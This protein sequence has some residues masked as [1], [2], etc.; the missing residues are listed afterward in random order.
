[1]KA[2][3]IESIC[4]LSPLQQGLIFHCLYSPESGVYLSQFN[5]A[6]PKLNI[7][8][9]K[10]SWQLMMERHSIFRTA[11]FWKEL[12]KPLQVVERRTAL[13]L[14]EK[15]WRHLS[16][17]EQQSQLE[18]LLEED[19]ARGF[20]LDHAPL[21]RLT[22]NRTGESSYQFIWTHHHLLLDGWSIAV[23]L[24][25]VFAHYEATLSGERLR[26]PPVRPFSDFIAWLSQRDEAGAER[27]WR[28]Y[29]SGF[30]AAT[31]L[32][33]SFDKH[34]GATGYGDAESR[35][36]IEQTEAVRT[37]ARRSRVTLNT[38]VGGAWAV[39]LARSAGV[40]EVVYGSVVSGRPAELE[41]VEGMV[42]L[43]INTLPVRVRVRGEQ[44]IGEWLQGLQREAAEVRQYEL[45]SLA[46]LQR[47]SEMPAATPLFQTIYGFENYPVDESLQQQNRGPEVSMARNPEQ[48]NYPLALIAMP[49]RQMHLQISYD[50]ALF[51]R[52]TVER[53]LGRLQRVLV[54][55]AEN[56][57]LPVSRLELL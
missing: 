44:P 34:E 7:E 20:D 14:E 10:S 56:P 53:I 43:F 32:P 31:P 35:L 26:L 46:Q 11:F 6:F 40:E 50:R 5:C 9:F 17:D 33:A 24:K 30:T 13:P 22:L 55:M 29:L 27:F 19:R 57:Q 54:G 21:M 16:V 15:D 39:M 28:R 4:E 3:N 41:G 25:E 37:L 8:A 42:G 52:E 51:S 12:N 36:T 38:V 49:A 45:T 47:W 23:V 48:A 2:K 1:M 18:K